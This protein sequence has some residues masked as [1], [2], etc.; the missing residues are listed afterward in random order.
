MRTV[1]ATDCGAIDA[2]AASQMRCR[3]RSFSAALSL[4]GSFKQLCRLGDQ[5]FCD[6]RIFPEQRQSEANIGLAAII[7]WSRHDRLRAS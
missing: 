5:S 3:Q 2:F 7:F 6:D 4:F 1:S